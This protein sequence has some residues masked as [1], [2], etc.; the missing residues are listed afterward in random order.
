MSGPFDQALFVL[1]DRDFCE[2]C[3]L[4]GL[5]AQRYVCV[6]CQLTL[7]LEC[8]QSRAARLK[9]V[10]NMLERQQCGSFYP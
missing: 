5:L 9:F 7:C 6:K 2:E 3:G 8:F 1:A 4:F 10:C